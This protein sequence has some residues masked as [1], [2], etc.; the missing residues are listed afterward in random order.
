VAG[1][2]LLVGF[3]IFHVYLTTT[4]FKP[5]SAIKAMI[6]GWEEMSDEEAEVAVR[7]N[8]RMLMKFSQRRI[9]NAEGEE[10]DSMFDLS[11]SEE[12]GNTKAMMIDFQKKLKE[13]NVGY[14]KI[15]KDG[16][17]IEVNDVWKK[18]Y[19][20]TD[21]KDP[22]GKDYRLN[23]KAEDRKTVEN[24]FAQVLKGKTITGSIVARYNSDGTKSYHT[25]SASPYY[26]NNKIAGMEGYIIDKA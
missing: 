22:I 8:I 7:E 10:D 23:R 16:I 26:E 1:A 12:I 11:L 20:R 6:T 2:F 25:I 19:S 13:S 18:L 9:M 21:I 5:L 3:V 24:V 17:Y 15:N 4:G 14:F